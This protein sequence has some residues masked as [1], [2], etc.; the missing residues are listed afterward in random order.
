MTDRDKIHA[1]IPVIRNGLRGDLDPETALAWVESILSK[2]TLLG[3]P[4]V[5]PPTE[6]A[7]IRT[8]IDNGELGKDLATEYGVSI[9]V[10][11]RIKHDVG[12]RR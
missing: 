11:S 12:R 1:A 6:H 4:P 5:I 8:R 7:A 3:R 2:P 9:S 10:I